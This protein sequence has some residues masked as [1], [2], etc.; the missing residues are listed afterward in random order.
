MKTN[1][2]KL[3][4]LHVYGG[5]SSKRNVL[6]ALVHMFKLIVNLD[7]LK[8]KVNFPTTCSFGIFLEILS[9]SLYMVSP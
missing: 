1:Q 9:G 5:S 7:W 3:V 2:Q 8:L 6:L 4:R